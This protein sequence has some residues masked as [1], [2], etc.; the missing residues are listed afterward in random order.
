MLGYFCLKTKKIN[1]IFID[2]VRY[3]IPYLE[4]NYDTVTCEDVD[5]I[6]QTLCILDSL[7]RYGLVR[8]NFDKIFPSDFI[9]NHNYLLLSKIKNKNSKFESLLSQNDIK[10]ESNKITNI[11]NVD[12]IINI[13][14]IVYKN[15]LE[16]S[17]DHY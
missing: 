8:N 12:Y 16:S 3:F 13:D 9:E 4:K 11:Y 2:Y 10:F 15:K 14:N 17:C 7:I 6:L 5:N 1:P